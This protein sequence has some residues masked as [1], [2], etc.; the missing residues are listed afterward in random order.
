MAKKR[1]KKLKAKRAKKLRTTGQKYSAPPEGSEAATEAEWSELGMPKP[2]GAPAPSELLPLDETLLE[3]ANTLWQFGDWEGLAE[4]E[5]DALHHHPD[6]AKLALLAAEGHLQ[7]GQVQEARTLLK[8]AQAWGVAPKTVHRVLIAG[9]YNSLGKASFLKGEVNQAMDHFATSVRVA[10]PGTEHRL[11]TKARALQ[12]VEQLVAA[13]PDAGEFVLG[14]GEF[15][16]ALLPSPLQKR[17]Q[18]ASEDIKENQPPTYS[19]RVQNRVR[20]LKELSPARAATLLTAISDEGFDGLN[21]RVML[22]ESMGSGQEFEKSIISYDPSAAD[23]LRDYHHVRFV[24]EGFGRGVLNAHRTVRSLKDQQLYF[25]KVYDPLS[26]EA[27]KIKYFT[28]HKNYVTQVWP[29]SVNFPETIL[30]A[31]QLLFAYFPYEEGAVKTESEMRALLEKLLGG[32]SK[33][34]LPT[35]EVPEYLQL[36][37]DSIYKSAEQ[38]MKEA[39]PAIARLLQSRLQGIEQT[40]WSHGSFEEGNVLAENCLIDLDN[41]GFYPVGWDLAFYFSKSRDCGGLE[42][43]N[44]SISEMSSDI[45]DHAVRKE[46]FLN[47]PVFL[48]ALLLRSSAKRKSHDWLVGYVLQSEGPIPPA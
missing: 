13:A 38:S 11:S 32:Q 30:E 22:S 6:R 18:E 19:T 4:I 35:C 36:R 29:G 41:A 28:A 44:A 17:P 40:V 10:L 9:V 12:Q 24:K 5:L 20:D 23:V 8:E 21:V 15:A 34:R 42:N 37:T 45:H 33:H 26:L 48:A 27:Q 47:V 7:L 31:K 43:L 46:I 1:K 16:E 14:V 2:A 25:E 3:R 39:Y